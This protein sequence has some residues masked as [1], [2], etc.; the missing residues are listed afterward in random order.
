MGG[1]RYPQASRAE[2]SV[3]CVAGWR[4]VLSAA[5][6]VA[7]VGCGQGAMT[8]AGSQAPSTAVSTVDVDGGGPLVSWDESWEF[9]SCADLPVLTAPPE[10]YRDKPFYMPDEAAR[11]EVEAWAES[12]PGYEGFWTDRDDHD[13]WLSVGFSRGAAARQR[14][15]EEKFP[16]VRVVAVPLERTRAELEAL[17]SRVGR[18]L[19]PLLAEHDW[20]SLDPSVHKGVAHLKVGVLT[21][22]LRRAIDKGFTGAPLCVEGI[23]PASLP[24]PGPQPEGGDGWRLLAEGEEIRGGWRISLAADAASY[25]GLWADWDSPIP[26]VDF[27]DHVVISFAANSP[28]RCPDTRLND[29]AVDGTVI[30][31]EIVNL[32]AVT[33]CS[34]DINPYPYVVALERSRL[35]P[36]PFAIQTE[37]ELSGHSTLD[38]RLLVDADLSKAGAVPDPGAVNVDDNIP[39]PRGPETMDIAAGVSWSIRFDRRCGIEWLGKMNGVAW[40]ADEPIPAE[41]EKALEASGAVEVTMTARAEPEPLIEATAHGETIVYKP[42][43]EEIPKCQP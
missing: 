13:G 17:A 23:D 10:A 35:P 31:A 43:D 36:G 4:R 42:T 14:D 8:S 9:P 22:E 28:S 7:V 25:A 16:N 1:R 24:A 32:S 29:V 18:E 12:Q 27:Q 41:W 20:V 40:R 2:R 30:Y 34:L 26:E 11:A 15:L 33:M 38:E 37:A 3:G 6:L 19:A 39:K 21:E 5:A